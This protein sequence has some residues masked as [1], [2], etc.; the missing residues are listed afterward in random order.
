MLHD[1]HFLQVKQGLTAAQ[2]RI[3]KLTGTQVDLLK[4]PN[5][6]ENPMR[7]RD[8]CHQIK[9]ERVRADFRRTCDQLE[10]ALR[11][12]GNVKTQID[13]RAHDLRRRIFGRED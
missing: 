7:P 13:V 1:E 12:I 4:H 6:T 11:T 10:T 2:N 5:F 9:D 3:L 8:G